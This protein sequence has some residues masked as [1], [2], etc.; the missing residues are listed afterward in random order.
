MLQ[1]NTTTGIMYIRV[2]CAFYFLLIFL[3]IFSTDGLDI[4][5]GTLFSS[6][7]CCDSNSYEDKASAIS[8]ATDQLYKDG[9]LDKENVTFKYVYS[10]LLESLKDLF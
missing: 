10:H 3:C 4:R 1:G 9:V 2:V 6:G 7:L 5:I 8:I